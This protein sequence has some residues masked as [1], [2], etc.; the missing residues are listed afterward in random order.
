MNTFFKKI[1]RLFTD[2]YATIWNTFGRSATHS[3]APSSSGAGTPTPP[4]AHA[5]RGASQPTKRKRWFIAV[6]RIVKI[7]VPLAI[8]GFIITTAANQFVG[9]VAFWCMFSAI[10]V[11]ITLIVWVRKG[12]QSA[13]ATFLAIEVP[14]LLL[15][16]SYRML[17]EIPWKSVGVTTL[18]ILGIVA[19]VGALGWL[20]WRYRGGMTGGG[21]EREGG[22]GIGKIVLPIGFVLVTLWIY[23]WGAEQFTGMDVWNVISEAKATL[24]ILA[25]V[26]CFGILWGR[27]GAGSKIA[28][29]MVISFTLIIASVVLSRKMVVLYPEAR[30]ATVSHTYRSGIMEIQ[31]CDSQQQPLDTFQ[32]QDVKVLQWD[33]NV[34]S[35][36]TMLPYNGS[37]YPC[38]YSGSGNQ[39][40]W[41]WDIPG[42]RNVGSWFIRETGR[43]GEYSGEL[44]TDCGTRLQIQLLALY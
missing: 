30:T 1:N 8:I 13:L 21:T 32:R 23:L 12:W 31:I 24:P 17:K 22:V 16:W 19:A 41:V 34:Q 3:P 44:R 4:A 42:K 18:F 9:K 5:G 33:A 36:S 27:G 38:T 11:L 26:L 15:P 37:W 2:P 39:G 20:I 28:A 40:S 7:A 43:R 14:V 25:G 29:F 35:F 6:R 10:T